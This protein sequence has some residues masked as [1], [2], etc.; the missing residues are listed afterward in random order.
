MAAGKSLGPRIEPR[1]GMTIAQ[2]KASTWGE[3]IDIIEEEVSEGMIQTWHYDYISK[4]TISFDHM[5]V[6]TNI[7]Q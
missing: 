4:R 3:P 1:V 2:V 5:G 7:A 6:V